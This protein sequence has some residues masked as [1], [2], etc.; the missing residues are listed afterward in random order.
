S[1]PSAAAA[2]NGAFRS[3]TIGLTGSR[4]ASI[5]LEDDGVAADGRPH[6]GACALDL[7]RARLRAQLQD[8]LADLAPAVHLGV[9]ELAAVGVDG[10]LAAEAD[11]AALD[12]LQPFARRAEAEVLQRIDRQ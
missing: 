10:P 8:Q 5:P 6:G 9:A 7:A 1:R 4:I 3:L 11:P 12:E 2:Q